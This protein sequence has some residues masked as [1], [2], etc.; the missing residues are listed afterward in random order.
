VSIHQPSQTIL[1]R[2]CSI[3]GRGCQEGRERPDGPSCSLRPHDLNVLPQC[4]Q[5]RIDQ[6][7]LE[8][9][10]RELGRGIRVLFEACHR[11]ERFLSPFLASGR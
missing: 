7:A 9:R 3:P 8:E 6:A 2:V 5:L 11:E 1:Q 4:T 10:T